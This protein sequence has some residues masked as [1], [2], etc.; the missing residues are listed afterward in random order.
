MNKSDKLLM[1]YDNDWE[2]VEEQVIIADYT[3]INDLVSKF[4][5]RDI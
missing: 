4:K 3:K 2:D 1:D 5:D